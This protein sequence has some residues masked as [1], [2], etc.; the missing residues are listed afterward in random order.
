LEASRA[1]TSTGTEA[2]SAAAAKLASSA[3]TIHGSSSW[4][5][6]HRVVPAASAGTRLRRPQPGHL[7]ISPDMVVLTS[8]HLRDI[9]KSCQF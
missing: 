8:A 2:P 5:L 7:V 6:P 1:S 4:Q 9:G 3:S